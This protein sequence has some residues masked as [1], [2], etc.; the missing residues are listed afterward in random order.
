MS[1]HSLSDDDYRSHARERRRQAD[2][3]RMAYRRA[4]EQRAEERR[5][6][7]QLDDAA[8]FMLPGQRRAGWLAAAEC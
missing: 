8:A 5:L 6:Q 2:C 7:W 4:I 3:Q 1:H